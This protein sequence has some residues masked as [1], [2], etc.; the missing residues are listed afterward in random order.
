MDPSSSMNLYDSPPPTLKLVAITMSGGSTFHALMM[1]H[2]RTSCS[3]SWS[4][5]RYRITWNNGLVQSWDPSQTPI[6]MMGPT[7]G[8][9]ES[10]RGGGFSSHSFFF[11]HPL[12]QWEVEEGRRVAWWQR[13]PNFERW[14]ER[15]MEERRETVGPRQNRQM[16]G[17]LRRGLLKL[18]GFGQSLLLNSPPPGHLAYLQTYVSLKTKWRP[19]PI[20]G[21]VA[22][23]F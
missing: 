1:C 21:Q 2:V 9:P 10:K 14:W 16:G 7:F 8:S 15:K 6:F 4:H 23:H 20:W 17:K 19:G 18:G 13:I 5:C 12:G 3:L 11:S 22:A